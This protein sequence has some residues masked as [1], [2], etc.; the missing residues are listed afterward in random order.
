M[1]AFM[2]VNWVHVGVNYAL[3]DAGQ[4]AQADA[5]IV[6]LFSLAKT[7]TFAD[8]F[9]FGMAVVAVCAIALRSSSLRG[10]SSGWAC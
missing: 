1:A 4:R 2:G 5:G 7:L 8:G 9:V 3:S 6:A 10:R